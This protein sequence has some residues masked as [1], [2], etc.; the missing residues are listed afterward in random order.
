MRPKSRHQN[1]LSNHPSETGQEPVE[2]VTRHPDPVRHEK[3]PDDDKEG[4]KAVDELYS[5]RSCLNVSRSEGS[6]GAGEGVELG[7][8]GCR[9]AA[10]FVTGLDRLGRGYS[11]LLR[12]I[13]SGRSGLGFGCHVGGMLFEN[14]RVSKQLQTCPGQLAARIG[15]KLK[16]T[17]SSWF[18]PEKLMILGP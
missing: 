13:R 6:D 7:L 2:R 9:E 15:N 3:D 4:E 11:S 14:Q 17:D 16:L 5:D 12:F 18:G 1:E 10:S 8:R